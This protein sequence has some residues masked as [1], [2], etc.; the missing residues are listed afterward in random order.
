M[1]KP[2]PLSAV[3]LLLFL[4]SPQLSEAQTPSGYLSSDQITGAPLNPNDRSI[5]VLI[6]GWTGKSPQNPPA[7]MFAEGT[8]TDWFQMVQALR[9]RLNG[10]G[11]K[12]FL[13][14]VFREICV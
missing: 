10:T 5:V 7:N 2:H 8:D 9:T 4:A 13:F 1:R 6:H 12:L 14:R 11:S 3:P